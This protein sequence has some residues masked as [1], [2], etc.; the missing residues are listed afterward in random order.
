[1]GEKDAPNFREKWTGSCVD[2]CNC[3]EISDGSFVVYVCEK[4]DFTIRGSS[5]EY[6]CNDWKEQ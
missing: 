6:V 3:V 1:M 5:L 2:C 4:Y